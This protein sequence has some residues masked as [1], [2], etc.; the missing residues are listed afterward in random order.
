M[1]GVEDLGNK[2]SWAVVGV[3]K[4]G[5]IHGATTL[6]SVLG[7]LLVFFWNFFI[8]LIVYV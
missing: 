5:I 8:Q 1:S 2:H 4:G 7:K 3:E 6:A